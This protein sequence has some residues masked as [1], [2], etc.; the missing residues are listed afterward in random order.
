VE[1]QGASEYEEE[2]TEYSVGA[3]YLYDKTIMSIGYTSSSENDYEAE[4]I[5]FGI[6]QDFFGDLTNISLGFTYGSDTVRKNETVA[7]GDEPFEDTADHRRYRIGISQILTKN[8]LMA[9]NFETVIDGG[10]LNNPYRQVRALD[11]STNFSTAI[12]QPE[13]YPR[14]RNSDA[15]SIRALYYLPYRA[16]LKGEYRSFSDSWG[17]DADSF[18]LRYVHP[19][20]S[21]GVILEAKYRAYSQS[22]ADFYS[23]L[24]PYPDSSTNPIEFRAR[25][26]EMSEFT[27][28]TIGFGGSYELNPAWMPF[29]DKS[30]VNLYWDFIQFDYDNFHDAS[31]TGYPLGEEPLYSFDAN[32]IRLYC[33][34]WY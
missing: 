11:P 14:T 18:E 21:Y 25:D 5:G 24:F 6:S 31:A 4:T 23:D 13:F 33:S 8:L 30:T 29:F 12:F 16:S 28:Q 32:I 34:F 27:T 10:Y 22:Q 19:L 20:E 2:R 1:A 7:P 15:F 17:I 9:V 26:K 3:D